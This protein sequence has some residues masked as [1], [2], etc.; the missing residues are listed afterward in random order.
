M[1]TTFTLFWRN[2]RSRETAAPAFCG[3]D[4]GVASFILAWLT[5]ASQ[6]SSS[7]LLISGDSFISLSLYLKTKHVLFDDGTWFKMERI[8]WEQMIKDSHLLFV[9][10][11]W[12]ASCS[13]SLCWFSVSS[14]KEPLSWKFFPFV[15]KCCLH[16]KQRDS[17]EVSHS[18]THKEK[19]V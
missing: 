13:L 15:F 1:L 5:L 8:Q 19:H 16:I 2:E 6:C 12:A 17:D 10:G 4:G 3:I 7:F 9:V 18:A 11:Q 14:S